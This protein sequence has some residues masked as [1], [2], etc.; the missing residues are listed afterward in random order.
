MRHQQSFFVTPRDEETLGFGEGSNSQQSKPEHAYKTFSYYLATLTLTKDDGLSVLT[1]LAMTVLPP[2][3]A[4]LNK[5]KNGMAR[6]E[7]SCKRVSEFRRPFH[8]ME[9]K[10]SC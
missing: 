10:G 2:S 1:A 7:D 6:C 4:D 5:F 3:P 9:R 8:K